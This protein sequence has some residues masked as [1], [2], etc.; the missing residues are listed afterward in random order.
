M[1]GRGH[2]ILRE[3]T[4]ELTGVIPGA[5]SAPELENEE[6]GGSLAS[7][8]VCRTLDFEMLENYSGGDSW[9]FVFMG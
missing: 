9:I 8:I 4:P 7:H 6:V 3:D 1:V 2:W 5:T